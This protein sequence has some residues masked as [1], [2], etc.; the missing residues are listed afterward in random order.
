[1]TARG[2]THENGQ[3]RRVPSRLSVRIATHGPMMA[4]L[5]VAE[6]RQ[7]PPWIGPAQTVLT[8]LDRTERLRGDQ[9]VRS[10]TSGPIRGAPSEVGTQRR[11][12]AGLLRTGANAQRALPGALGARTRH[13]GGRV[14]AGL[15]RRRQN[16]AGSGA[17]V[18]SRWEQE[19]TLLHPRARRVPPKAPDL[20]GRGAASRGAAMHKLLSNGE[21]Q[22]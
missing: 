8:V 5:P 1:M 4:R 11:G 7:E 12:K 9:R 6:R 20:P 21:R 2:A 14:K 22:S 10:V 17:P 13:P 16:A 15:K 3:R 19:P 18:G